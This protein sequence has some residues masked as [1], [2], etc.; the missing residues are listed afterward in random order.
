MAS[1]SGGPGRFESPLV[2]TAG[3]SSTNKCL[4]W[5]PT[6]W[7]EYSRLSGNTIDCSQMLYCWT[8]VSSHCHRRSSQ[9]PSRLSTQLAW[10][11]FGPHRRH[12]SSMLIHNRRLFRSQRLAPNDSSSTCSTRHCHC[13]SPTSICCCSSRICI[14]RQ[15]FP[16]F[17]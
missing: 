5:G 10:H 15:T 17:L 13:R 3:H 8:H 2:W 6:K 1:R 11:R 14:C 4:R 9:M 12:Y 7:N 16:R